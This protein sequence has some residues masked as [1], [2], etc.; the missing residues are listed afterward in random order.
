M[1][2]P[3]L[4]TL[5]KCNATNIHIHAIRRRWHW[6]NSI[7]NYNNSPDKDLVNFNSKVCLSL[8]DFTCRPNCS[9]QFLSCDHQTPQTLL[10]GLYYFDNL[11][12]SN[13]SSDLMWLLFIKKRCMN[14]Q[15]WH[16]VAL[17]PN[18]NV[19][20]KHYPLINHRVTVF[21]LIIGWT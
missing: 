2:L 12:S 15:P 6:K 7:L 16:S 1:H 3:I 8:G 4:N 18:R 11:G 19:W 5:L 20:S 9:L 21:S 10:T 13:Q 17:T 14:E